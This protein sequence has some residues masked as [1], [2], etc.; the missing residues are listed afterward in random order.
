MGNSLESTL[1][2]LYFLLMVG[3]NYGS[4]NTEETKIDNTGQGAMPQPTTPIVT[5]ATATTG[6]LPLRRQTNGK[7]RARREITISS[8]TSGILTQA[9]TEGA[10]Y[11]AGA[12]L[13]ATDTRAPELARDRAAAA[14][15][16][17]AF[18]QRDLLLRLSTNLP[19]GDTS[20]T[21]LARDNL[22]IQSGLPAAE[23]A[24]TEAEYQLALAVQTAPFDGGIA[25]VKVQAGSLVNLGEE[26]CTLVDPT[27]LEAEFSL[28]EQEIGRLG[29]RQR[30]F[31]SPI[32]R[33]DLRIPA[34]LDI[35]NP[36]VDEGGLLRVRARLGRT[37]KE[38]LYPGMNVDII[39]E[40]DSREAVLVPKSAIVLRSGKTLVF[41][42]DP[43]SER[44]KWQY[45]T[46]A[47]EN[48]EQVALSE[49]VEPG[50]Q[51]IVSGNLNLDHDSRVRVEVK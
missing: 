4:P 46:V 34:T 21:Q 29:D 42:Y 32:A 3:C 16:E 47:Y 38:K 51:V 35:I 18:R 23:V 13:A 39:L 50:Q 33:P 30:V 44:A 8:Q 10:Y 11:E 37:G 36:R 17:A 40:S 9:P 14:R 2:L 20:V 49:G 7:L 22:L 25:D 1:I 45:V 6:R 28:L 19:V 12:T 31:V 26:I 5:L 41:T 24:L 48:N 43:E 15:E 27:S